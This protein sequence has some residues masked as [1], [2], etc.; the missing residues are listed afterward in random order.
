MELLYIKKT[1]ILLGI[2]LTLYGFT[3]CIKTN[4]PTGASS[5]NIINAIPGSNPLVT[6]FQPLSSSKIQNIL[7]WYSTALQID[8]GSCKEIGS[9]NGMTHLSLSQIDDT[10]TSIYSLNLNMKVGSIYS[11][12]LTGTDTLHVDTVLN[13]DHL[14]YFPGSDSVTGVRFANLST[15]SLPVMITLQA[16]TTHTPITGS[17]AYKTIT[18]FQQFSSTIEAQAN[19]YTFEFRDVASENV[20]ATFNYNI[21]PFV[22]VTVCLVGQPGTNAVTPQSVM[23]Y[24]NY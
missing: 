4:G 10:L 16:D 23:I 13:L 22:N 9:Y 14:P 5:L 3:S 6:N 7:M 21:V 2:M 24:N 18:P 19:G 12:F 20:L 1:S 17:I 11:L 8:Y 15:G